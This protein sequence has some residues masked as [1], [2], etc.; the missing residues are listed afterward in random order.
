[1]V[2]DEYYVNL[3]EMYDAKR[4]VLTEG[5][6]SAGLSPNQPEGS[7]YLLVDCSRMGVATGVE[8]AEVLL[9]R[10]L[11]GTMPGEAFYVGKPERPYVRACFSVSDASLAEAADRL[12]NADLQDI[13]C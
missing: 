11:V 12:A 3:R 10:G 13:L 2:D 9:D 6:A 1:M 5:F 8:A 4:R 7:Y